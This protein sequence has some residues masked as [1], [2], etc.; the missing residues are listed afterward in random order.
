MKDLLQCVYAV[1][2]TL[3]LEM[4]PFYLAATSKNCLKNVPHV[5]HDAIAFVITKAR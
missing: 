2:K 4:S 1:V 3:N 5:Q